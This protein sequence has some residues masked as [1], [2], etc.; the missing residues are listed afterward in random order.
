ISR[1]RAGTCAEARAMGKGAFMVGLYF[2]P[3]VASH[4]SRLARF[5]AEG[6]PLSRPAKRVISG[7]KYG[8][9]ARIS[10]LPGAPAEPAS[11]QTRRPGLLGKPDADRSVRCHQHR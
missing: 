2:I 3:K 6:G 8:H 11:A 10:T 4:S 9:Y 1:R 5:P 7:V